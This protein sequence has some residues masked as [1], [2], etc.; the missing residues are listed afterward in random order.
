MNSFRDEFIFET[1]SMPTAQWL[2]CLLLLPY[3]TDDQ[4]PHGVIITLLTRQ[5]DV[6]TSFWRNDD[7]IITLC[8]RSVYLFSPTTWK[9]P[10]FCHGFRLL[11]G[12]AV[13][14]IMTSSNG[15]ISALMAL[16]A[17]NS[18]VTGE[19]P[20]QRPVTRS[21][22]VFFDLHMNKRLSKHWWG[23]WFETPS[24]SL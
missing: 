19:F 21:F 4:R 8:G 13:S 2:V 7:V 6:P 18:P 23:W 12:S 22:G 17:G 20:T 9:R 11:P 3:R 5:N 10:L 1:L 16:Y 15:N 14:L 24:R